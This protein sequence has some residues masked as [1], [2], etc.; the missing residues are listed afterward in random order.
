MYIFV[1]ELRRLVLMKNNNRVLLYLI[2][3]IILY[4]LIYLATYISTYFYEI[5]R[6][7]F[8]RTPE[9]IYTTFYPIVL[10]LYAGLPNLYKQMKKEGIWTVDWIKLLVI[11]VPS[12][13]VALSYIILLL[14][15]EKGIAVSYPFP[16][17]FAMYTAPR[18]LSSFIF[19]YILLTS[20]K[21]KNITSLEDRGEENFI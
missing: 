13:L 15:S 18:F 9:A 20:F 1:D 3:V 5:S 6:S 10:G 8:N 19:G 4:L 16:A 14:I 12:L 17:I 7:T 21:K 2:Y 11:G